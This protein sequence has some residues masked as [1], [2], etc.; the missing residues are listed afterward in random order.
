MMT[1]ATTKLKVVQAGPKEWVLQY[2]PGEAQVRDEFDQGIDLMETGNDEKAMKKFLAVL[3]ACPLHIDAYHHLALLMFYSND[4][5]AALDLWG[6]AVR[7]GIESLPKEFV[8]GKDRLKWVCIENRPFLRAYKGLGLALFDTGRINSAHVIYNHLLAMNPNDNQGV[9]ALAVESAFAMNRPDEVLRI[10][11]KYKQDAMVDT[12]Y[13]RPLALLQL[14]KRALAEKA[15]IG[16]IGLSHAVAQ[17]LLK[18][19][20]R[21]PKD[22][23]LA[24]VTVGGADE[25][26]EY[27]QRLGKYWKETEGAL[28][29]LAEIMARYQSK[30]SD[31]KH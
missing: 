2:P 26:Y 17:E 24:Y 22:R 4:L 7:I 15:L 27:W 21:A 12:L 3:K 8:M 29:F 18:K 9:R 28:E 20:H 10:C 31:K 14:G 19:R 23:S 1:M 11:N 25:A 16:A 30:A 13:G 5:P 6:T